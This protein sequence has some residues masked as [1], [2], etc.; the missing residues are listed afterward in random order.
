MKYFKRSRDFQ[1]RRNMAVRDLIA[2]SATWITN[3]EQ[4]AEVYKS[5]GEFNLFVRKSLL[6]YLK[7]QVQLDCSQQ[8]H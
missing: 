2:E 5:N 7:K 4:V 8:D 1:T 3:E 6:R